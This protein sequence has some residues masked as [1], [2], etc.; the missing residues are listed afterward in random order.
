MNTHQNIF[1][2]PG[3]HIFASVQD[4]FFT[5]FKSRWDTNPLFCRLLYFCD[6][7]IPPS[8]LHSY[9]T[10]EDP[11]SPYILS[12]CSLGSTA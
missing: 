6:V 2:L 11:A 8:N 10:I 7:I 5:Y 3:S 1:H 9:K 4:E 12:I